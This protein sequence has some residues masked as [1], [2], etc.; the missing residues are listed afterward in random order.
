MN[1]RCLYSSILYI[2]RAI[3]YL[4]GFSNRVDSQIVEISII[5]VRQK[6]RGRRRC[7]CLIDKLLIKNQRLHAVDQNYTIINYKNFKKI[8]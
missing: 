7:S 8:K 4:I 6:S 1:H 2:E 3:N 5:A